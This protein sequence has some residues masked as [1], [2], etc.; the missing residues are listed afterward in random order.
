MEEHFDK[1]LNNLLPSCILQQILNLN[2]NDETCKLTGCDNDPDLPLQ[3]PKGPNLYRL[4]KSETLKHQVMA[5]DGTKIGGP[6]SWGNLK[7]KE[8]MFKRFLSFSFEAEVDVEVLDDDGQILPQKK[9]LTYLEEDEFTQK[10]V[11]P[12]S[13]WKWEKQKPNQDI[14][15]RQEYDAGLLVTI[16]QNKATKARRIEEYNDFKRGQREA[17]FPVGTIFRVIEYEKK[18]EG[19]PKHIIK[20][21]ELDLELFTESLESMFS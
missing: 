3:K 2:K 15:D 7:G 8:V 14:W 18:N 20:L 9:T 12:V 16:L 19:H 21:E 13:S 6:E 5:F 1:N 17:L 10:W 4:T 11:G